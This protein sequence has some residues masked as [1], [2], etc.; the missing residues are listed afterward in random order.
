MWVVR[1]ADPYI[2]VFDTLQRATRKGWLLFLFS[3]RVQRNDDGLTGFTEPGV[4]AP[5]FYKGAG[6]QR[7]T[8]LGKLPL[9]KGELLT[10]GDPLKE[11]L[12]VGI[13]FF[14]LRT[15]VFAFH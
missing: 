3:F 15:T 4:G 6:S 12:G 9:K 1:E 13:P 5:A 8:A 7:D 14:H 2:L 10:E 11:S